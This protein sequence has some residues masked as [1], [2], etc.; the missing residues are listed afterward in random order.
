MKL[1]CKYCGKD[2]LTNWGKRRKYCGLCNR[3]F[4]TKAAG[5]K[6]IRNRDMYLLDRSTYRRIGKKKNYSAVTIM[7]KVHKE[8]SVLSTPLDHLKKIVPKLPASWLWTAS[9]LRLRALSIMS[10]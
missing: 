7:E 4:R 5:R 6:P 8:I 1:V 2:G 9:I 3:T 10:L